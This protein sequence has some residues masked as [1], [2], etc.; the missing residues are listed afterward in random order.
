MAN[1]TRL[2]ETSNNLH[3]WQ[4]VGDHVAQRTSTAEATLT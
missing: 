1:A 3:G 2:D 4:S